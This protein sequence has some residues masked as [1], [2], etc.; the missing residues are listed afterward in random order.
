MSFVIKHGGTWRRE[1]IQG[2]LVLCGGSAGPD[3]ESRVAGT[4]TQ[5]RRVEN[6]YKEGGSALIT[7]PS[8]CSLT[9][10][11]RLEFCVVFEI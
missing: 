11:L 7:F 8:L 4:Q 9:S 2:T 5:G 6:V 1:R 10:L 3:G